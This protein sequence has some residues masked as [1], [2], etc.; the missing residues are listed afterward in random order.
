MGLQDLLAVV[1]G[2]KTA[3][4]L[5]RRNAPRR[6]VSPES[7]R[8][9]E[10]FE[11]LWSAIEDVICDECGAVIDDAE[12]LVRWAGSAQ[13]RLRQYREA[14][15]SFPAVNPYVELLKPQVDEVLASYETATDAVINRQ[16]DGTALVW[17][18][19]DAWRDVQALSQAFYSSAM[20]LPTASR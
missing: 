18:A 13:P 7:L 3:E 20:R 1:L 9:G 11:R 8:S 10:E 6:I 2:V 4:W 16:P 17:Q 12:G 19:R 15:R 5:E 14:M